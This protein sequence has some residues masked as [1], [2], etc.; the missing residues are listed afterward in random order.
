MVKFGQASPWQKIL[1]NEQNHMC[2]PIVPNNVKSV[3]LNRIWQQKEGVDI[4]YKTSA[5]N[6]YLLEHC[7]K[8]ETEIKS[9]VRQ[10]CSDISEKILPGN[11]SVTVNVNNYNT[12]CKRN[13]TIYGRYSSAGN[14]RHFQ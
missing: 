3:V 8:M 4:E 5:Y 11:V 14:S 13:C 7:G 1:F 9:E 10:L 2:I 12:D 6:C